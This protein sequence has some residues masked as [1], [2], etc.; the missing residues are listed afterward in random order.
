MNEFWCMC[1]RVL[2]L[3]LARLRIPDSFFNILPDLLYIRNICRILLLCVDSYVHMV[4]FSPRFEVLLIPVNTPINPPKNM[5]RLKMVT[6]N[7]PA[8]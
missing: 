7:T 8:T 3:F 5:Y 2:N 6:V 1:K 4:K